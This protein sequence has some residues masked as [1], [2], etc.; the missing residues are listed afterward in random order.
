MIMSVLLLLENNLKLLEQIVF[1]SLQF[2][3]FFLFVHPLASK[4]DLDMSSCQATQYA[5]LLSHAK[6]R[7][8]VIII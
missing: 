8:I 2:F 1:H 4:I 6:L 5:S 3:F 7:N